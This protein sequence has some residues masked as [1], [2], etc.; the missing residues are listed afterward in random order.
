MHVGQILECQRDSGAPNRIEVGDMRRAL[1]RDWSKRRINIDVSAKPQLSSWVD[2]YSS[3]G[4]RCTFWQYHLHLRLIDNST[5]ND[6]L[7]GDAD[8][9]QARAGIVTGRV[10][11]GRIPSKGESVIPTTH[12]GVPW[13]QLKSTVFLAFGGFGNG[14]RKTETRRRHVAIKVIVIRR[15]NSGGKVEGQGRNDMRW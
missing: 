5:W 4:L 2:D 12:K 8:N 15:M 13:A 1:L 14:R 6:R 7:D 9:I 10:G 11:E 3:P